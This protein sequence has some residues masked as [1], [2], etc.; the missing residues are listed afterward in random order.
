MRV[1]PQGHF[2]TSQ[3]KALRRACGD[4][5]PTQALAQLLQAG[6]ILGADRCGGG[7]AKP[8]GLRAI[9]TALDDL[10][11]ALGE[12]DALRPAGVF[13]SG[14]PAQKGVAVNRRHR[15]IPVRQRI[16]RIL[17]GI[18]KQARA[19]S[20]DALEDVGQHLFDH[21]LPQ[22]W[23]GDKLLAIGGLTERTVAAEHVEMDV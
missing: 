9:L 17:L 13:A 18:A 2:K 22:R 4:R 19:L 14:L 16:R 11:R 15:R 7:Q 1:P 21:R 12:L 10:G 3:P 23:R 5:W 8:P 20:L 6:P